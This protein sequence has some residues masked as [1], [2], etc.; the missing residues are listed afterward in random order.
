MKIQH[1]LIKNG[2]VH[3]IGDK[4]YIQNLYNNHSNDGSVIFIA[5]GYFSKNCIGRNY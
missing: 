3:A 2:R 5:F 1:G 4:D